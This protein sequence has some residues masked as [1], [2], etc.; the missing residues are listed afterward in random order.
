MHSGATASAAQRRRQ[1]DAPGVDGQ[2]AGI[3]R[4]RPDQGDNA[5]SHPNF[6]RQRFAHRD[7][8]G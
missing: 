5:G 3:W 8:D 6:A 1:R 2:L 4:D 7:G